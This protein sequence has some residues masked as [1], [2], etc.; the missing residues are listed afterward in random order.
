MVDWT[1]IIST[2][3]GF[4]TAS[5]TKVGEAVAT[6]AGEELFAI[7][8]KKFKDDKVGQ[9]ILSKFRKK[10]SRYENALIDIIKEKAKA[11]KSFE[12]EIRNIVEKNSQSQDNSTIK[13]IAN[14]IGNA[15]AAGKNASATSNVTIKN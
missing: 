14:G 8:K 5:I 3:V 10:P 12:N 11:D 4:M 13:Q 7:V 1:I 15:Q 9:D 6:K 2:A